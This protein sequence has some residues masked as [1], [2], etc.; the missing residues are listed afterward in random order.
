ME[1]FVIPS[2]EQDQQLLLPIINGITLLQKKNQN[3]LHTIRKIQ[4]IFTK[5]FWLLFL[6]PD[7]S[8]P[9][10]TENKNPNVFISANQ[11][12]EEEN[13]RERSSQKA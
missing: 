10:K 8:V 5:Q 4:K 13:H 9:W 3:N 12:Y 1:W 6:M 2:I 7:N 11:P